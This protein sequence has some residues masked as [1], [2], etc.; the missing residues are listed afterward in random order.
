MNRKG[1]LLVIV[2]MMSMATWAQEEEVDVVKSK[3][4]IDSMY[5]KSF[6]DKFML[7]LL[8]EYKFNRIDVLSRDTT[9]IEYR[10][11]NTWLYGIGFAYKWLA[12]DLAFRLPWNRGSEIKGETKN[13]SIGLGIMG[14]KF[15][16]RIFYEK[17]Q[18]YYMDNINSW[19][20]DYFEENTHYP[21]R[22]DLASSIF[23]ASVNYGFNYKRFSNK[24]T[25]TQQERQI[26][27]A[28][29]FTAGLVYARTL[30]QSNNSLV[31]DEWKAHFSDTLAEATG[32]GI[33]LFG[34]S[35]G[36]LRNIPL[37]KNKKWFIDIALIPGVSLQRV[38]VKLENGNAYESSNVLG[39]QAEGRVSLGFNGDTWYYGALGRY[40]GL[41]NQYVQTNP[42]SHSYIYTRL[43][44]GYKFPMRETR[45]KFFKKLGF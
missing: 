2:M 3:T 24:A 27:G 39:F 37:S 42:Q 35:G 32:Y 9:G 6:A 15:W 4:K 43:Y 44:V 28:G 12:V 22:Q 13:T 20:P 17:N 21:Y 18:G 41:T 5:I 30:V 31:P 34:V 7:R 26:L 45:S 16:T 10:T 19:V 40:Y 11:N 23:Y 36:Y 29:S 8:A 14:G 33:H 1:V 25:M 38:D